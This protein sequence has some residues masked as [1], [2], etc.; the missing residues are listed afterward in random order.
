[1]NILHASSEVFPYSKTGGLADATA[2]LA[3][4]QAAA[5][6]TV[7]LVTP[8]YRGIHEKLDD[9]G[10]SGIELQVPLGQAGLGGAGTRGA[11]LPYECKQDGQ[12]YHGQA[13]PD[14]PAHG[15]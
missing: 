2:A 1:M 12:D 7:T 14:K 13:A 5:G 15:S 3:R 4:A 10:P 9:I 11:L 8:L 6:H